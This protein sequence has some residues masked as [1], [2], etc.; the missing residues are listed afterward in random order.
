MTASAK[1]FTE[2]RAALQSNTKTAGP[3][4]TAGKAI[5]KG[6]GMIGDVVAKPFARGAGQAIRQGIE[7][8]P[9]L[10]TNL[11]NFVTAHPYLTSGGFLGFSAGAAMMEP[12]L[13][14]Y[15]EKIKDHLVPSNQEDVMMD[16]G[17]QAF[18][19]AV[20]ANVGEG[21]VGLLG[22][23][24]SKG[25]SGVTSIPQNIARNNMFKQLQETDDVLATANIADLQDAYHTMVRFAPTL[26][27][28][29]NAVRS[30]L[31][32]ATLYGSGPNVISI[33]QLADAEKTLGG[34]ESK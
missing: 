23:F 21:T 28:D 10:V 24:M 16:E 5:G 31:R 29:K 34:Y 3:I 33:K 9:G 17:S 15:A 1:S 32:E 6:L 2:K 14:A 13:A 25:V 8:A 20:G 18:A 27:T 11:T 22:D 12:T 4:G 7:K 26:A 19:K 30:F